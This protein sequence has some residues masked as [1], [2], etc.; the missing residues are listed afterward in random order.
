VSWRGSQPLPAAWMPFGRKRMQTQMRLS[1]E[2]YLLPKRGLVEKCNT[3]RVKQDGKPPSPRVYM[4]Y[5]KFA[6]AADCMGRVGDRCLA[7]D[8]DESQLS[9]AP[10]P[11]RDGMLLV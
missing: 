5:N 4:Y 9:L 3:R 2:L 6:R 1:A 7:A 8:C 11:S 10:E